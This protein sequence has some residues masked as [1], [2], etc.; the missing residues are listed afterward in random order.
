[1][2]L[3]RR[4]YI[5]VA[6]IVLTLVAGEWLPWCFTAGIAALWVLIA[7]VLVD[8]GLLYHRSG[9]EASRHMAE[10]FSN[11]DDNEVTISIASEYPFRLSLEVIDEV[12]HVFQRRDVLFT[13]NLAAHGACDIVYR[14][15]PVK[16]GVYGFGQIRVFASTMM[17]LVQR[18][19]T[20]GQACDIAVYPSYL[21]LNRYE[22]L[23]M[24]NNLTE[25]GIKR[26]RRVGN[27]TEFEQ[28][29]EYV[30]GDEYRSINWKA[31][32]R[33]G[34][35]MVNV[36]QDE[37]SQ[38]VFNVIDKGRVMRQAFEGMTLLDY[39]INASLVLSYVATHKEDKAGIVTFA[40]EFGDYIP[41]D[42]QG[43]H[44]MVINEA[45]YGLEADFDDSDFAAL[46]VNVDRLVRRRSLL[47]LY[48]NFTS[49]D[50][51][52]RQLPYFRRLNT[53][54]RLLVVFFDD[55]ETARY[56]TTRPQGVRGYYTRVI[57]R[58]QLELKRAIVGELRRNGI[59]SLLTPPSGLTI[60][61]INKYL[62]M[63]TRKLF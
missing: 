10:R 62:E 15:R 36:Y 3:T 18:R 1:M 25:L 47:V 12:P 16:R 61:V 24:S 11:G 2:Y 19:F 63:K 44:M 45:L 59:Y 6:A 5:V 13:H 60:N 17:G 48:T 56:V 30:E 50:G 31:S 26:I 43:G 14:L 51:M 27:N 29:K 28:I 57:A 52:R 46:T 9:I 20:R 21:M 22:L 33:R 54:H 39:A 41:A 35:L 49:L 40:G 7:A 32:A 34:Q 23:A 37:R 58:R 53:R 4:F 38:Q 42:K 55:V 8:V